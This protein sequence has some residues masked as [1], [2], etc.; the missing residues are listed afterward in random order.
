[1]DETT[2]RTFVAPHLK[3]RYQEK[4]GLGSLY[5]RCIVWT[6]VLIRSCLRQMHKE[7]TRV[8]PRR[9]LAERRRSAC[10]RTMGKEE[11][12]SGRDILGIKGT[13]ERQTDTTRSLMT[14]SQ[15]VTDCETIVKGST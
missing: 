12:Q 13:R 7:R 14:R 9:R 6:V 10:R 11:S 4:F 5:R 8:S 3:W 15:L 1:M 2:G